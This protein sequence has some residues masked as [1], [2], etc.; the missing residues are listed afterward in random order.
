MTT[1]ETCRDLR[2]ALDSLEQATVAVRGALTRLTDPGRPWQAT[3]L[4]ADVESYR[5][6]AEDV[7]PEL[8]R[9]LIWRTAQGLATS[10]AECAR[11]MGR[12]RNDGSTRRAWDVLYAIRPHLRAVNPFTPAGPTGPSL[13]VTE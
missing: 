8:A 4:P 7:V 2:K 1:Y 13:W 9:I 3:P 5:G 12:V 6:P 11:L 10:R